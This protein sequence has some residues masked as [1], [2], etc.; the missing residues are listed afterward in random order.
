MNIKIEETTICFRDFPYD[1]KPCPDYKEYKEQSSNCMSFVS[2]IAIK[3]REN[4]GR[5]I[6]KCE[7]YSKKVVKIV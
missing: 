7:R 4:H 1:C 6:M 2:S 3:P 5:L